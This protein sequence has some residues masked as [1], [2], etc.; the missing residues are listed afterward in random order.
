VVA[1]ST[2]SVEVGTVVV[3]ASVVVAGVVGATV[4][5]VLVGVD[6]GVVVGGAVVVTVHLSGHAPV[7]ATSLVHRSHVM[8]R[9]FTEE[10]NVTALQTS[11]AIA[12]LASMHLAVLNAAGSR[13]VRP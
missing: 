3:C 7:T 10:Q 13:M 1:L 9:P 4:G 6:V 5:V 8:H 12:A 11:C 2:P